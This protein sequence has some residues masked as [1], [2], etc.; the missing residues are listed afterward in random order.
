M[1]RDFRQIDWSDAIAEDCRDL[2]RLAIGEDLERGFD[3][4][5]VV[6]VPDRTIGRAEL[7][8]RCAGVVAGLPAAQLALAEFDPHATWSPVVGDGAAVSA[9]QCI[10]RVAGPARTLLT[11]ERLILNMLGRLSGIATLTR[12]Y[13]N[14]VAG[15]PARIYDTRKTTPGW[16]S[17][18]K[19]AVRRGGGRNHRLGLY[20]AILIKD[21]HVALGS[22][23]TEGERYS[24]AGAVAR[25]RQFLSSL[26]GGDPRRELI[27]EV[28][29]DTLDQL[30]EVMPAGPDLVLLDNMDPEQLREAVRRRDAFAPGI[31]LEA[32]GGVNLRTVGCIA[33]TGV[34][35]I[36]V[37]ALTHS[38]ASFDIG[39]D[40][41]THA[42]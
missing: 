30:D 1:D 15:T 18:E 34:D 20:D 25:V 36:S 28:E 12:Q 26:P 38:A 19:Y 9:G 33:Q 27:V 10:A 37:G 4:T 31:E 23:A 8:A 6:L 11:A 5:T 32:S 29:V 13:V 3:W 14:A 39:M 24:A 17:L 22:T 40:W 21:N 41:G 35:R 2:V 16:R 7:V 42:D